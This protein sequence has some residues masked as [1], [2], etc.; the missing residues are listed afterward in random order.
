M[1]KMLALELGGGLS[2]VLKK[3]ISRIAWVDGAPSSAPTGY[4]MAF[5]YTNNKLYIYNANTAAWKSVQLA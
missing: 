1:P 2:T 5:D 3:G 4:M